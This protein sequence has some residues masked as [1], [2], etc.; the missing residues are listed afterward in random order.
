MSLPEVA[1]RFIDAITI[2]DADA[3]RACYAPDAQIW[4]NFDGV[5]QTV[6]EHIA[7]M[8]AMTKRVADRRYVVHRLEPIEGGYLQQHTLELVL[9]D[10]RELATEAVAL[11][12]V[13]DEGRIAR[14][15]EWLDPAPVLAMFG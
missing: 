11:V 3:A 14:I 6:E 5:T 9:P 1:R 13:D 10:G 7:L 8:D 12:T 15:D 4:H 2:G